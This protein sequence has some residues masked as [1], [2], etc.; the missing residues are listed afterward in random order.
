MA[1]VYLNH[2]EINVGGQFPVVGEYA[3]SFLLVDSGMIDV[4]LSRFAGKPKI[5]A[6]I[7]SIDSEIG[8][9]I[10]RQLDRLSAEWPDCVIL[11]I[12]VDTPYALSR[13]MEQEHFRRVQLLCTLRG[14]DFHKDYGVMI[15]DIPLS[16]FMATAL[17]GLNAYDIVMYSELV[18]DLSFEP[19]YGAMAECLFPPVEEESDPIIDDA[20][21][22]A[23][24]ERYVPNS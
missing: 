13:V 12:S 10:A 8:L 16:G 2:T 1:T 21:Q 18:P 15:T 20:E 17:I 7:P 4:P 24:L 9:I 19:D 14:R 11:V 23:K 3:H 6:V 5:I 22:I